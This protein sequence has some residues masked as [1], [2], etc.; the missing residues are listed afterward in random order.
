MMGQS[1][2]VGRK[3][4]EFEYHFTHYL[5]AV[6]SA[7]VVMFTDA[8]VKASAGV[9]TVFPNARQ[10]WCYWHIVKNVAKNLKG[11][12]DHDTF[13]KSVR[14]M[15]RAHRQVSFVVFE[16]MW[17]VEILG[18]QIPSCGHTYLSATW[19]AGK[20]QCWVRCF[21]MGVF[22]RGIVWRGS[23]GRQRRAASRPSSAKN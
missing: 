11:V 8:C 15:A 5:A 14:P 20:V 12:L 17:N 23:I 9:A 13:T 16:H 19:G 4:R 21:Q 22:I 1:I 2:D 7:P 3:I 6:G 18:D 10:F